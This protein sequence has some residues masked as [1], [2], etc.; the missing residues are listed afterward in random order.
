MIFA[1]HYATERLGVLAVGEHLKS[2]FGLETEFIELP[3]GH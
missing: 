1:G 2:K 3:T